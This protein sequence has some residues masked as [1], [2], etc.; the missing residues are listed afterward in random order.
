MTLRNDKSCWRRTSERDLQDPPPDFGD[1][2]MGPL[3]D[4]SFSP[5]MEPGSEHKQAGSALLDAVMQ[6]EDVPL[7]PALAEEYHPPAAAQVNCD[8]LSACRAL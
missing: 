2:D 3:P 8:S 1:H 4:G 5:P 7:T 6:P